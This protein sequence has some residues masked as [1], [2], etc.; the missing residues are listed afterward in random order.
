MPPS[1]CRYWISALAIA[2]FHA[3][4]AFATSNIC[5]VR[6]FTDLL[7]WGA[8]TPSISSSYTAASNHF[9]VGRGAPRVGTPRMVGSEGRATGIA[10]ARHRLLRR[11]LSGPRRLLRLT[12]GLSAELVLLPGPRV[13]LLALRG[14]LALLGCLLGLSAPRVA[15]LGLLPLLG[16]A[17]DVALLVS[18][19]RCAALA[20]VDLLRLRR[21]VLRRRPDLV[22]VQLDRRALVALTIRERPLLETALSD[23][24]RPLLE[25]FADVLRRVAPDR[26]AQEQRL[27]VLPL[28]GLPVEL[29]RRRSDR[30]RCDRDTRLGEAQFR[31]GGQIPDNANDGVVRHQATSFLVV[32]RCVCTCGPMMSSMTPRTMSRAVD[33]GV[34]SPR[35]TA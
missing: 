21:R 4:S 7:P 22:H 28:P 18:A 33:A 6:R 8:G 9:Q 15:L 35:L 30:E 24:P 25:R 23:D 3:G 12:L 1:A 34:S 2:R 29:P 5:P 16:V 26:T 32:A 19:L 17:G 31:I 20:P 11:L 10:D 13:R 27:L 14:A